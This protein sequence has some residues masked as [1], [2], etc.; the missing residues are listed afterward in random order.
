MALGRKA[1][2]RYQFLNE[3]STTMPIDA[4]ASCKRPAADA[5]DDVFNTVILSVV[6]DGKAMPGRIDTGFFITIRATPHPTHPTHPSVP[7]R[8]RNVPYRTKLKP[9]G[10][11]E[12]VLSIRV[13]P[14]CPRSRP[15]ACG[16]LSIIF[17]SILAIKTRHRDV[18]HGHH[19]QYSCC[20]PSCCRQA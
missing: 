4:R 13:S 17:A 20:L 12:I 7:L 5:I 19:H 9:Q 3:I 6:Y 2:F 15:A 16:S 14:H 11:I 10:L 18:M 8:G 1:G